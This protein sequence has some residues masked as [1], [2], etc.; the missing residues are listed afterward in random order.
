[1]VAIAI[2]KKLFSKAA[3]TAVTLHASLPEQVET[4]LKNACLHMLAMAKKSGML[5]TGHAKISALQAEKKA[6]FI[7]RA[8]DSAYA[9]Q[10]KKQSSGGLPVVTL[11]SNDEL[12]STL[13]CENVV[14]VA[15][16]HSAITNKCRALIERYVSYIR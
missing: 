5:V 6:A 14:H 16:K 4:L 2:Q 11:F 3:K 10:E 8:C 12:S 1:M 9:A 13:G 7:L 15:L